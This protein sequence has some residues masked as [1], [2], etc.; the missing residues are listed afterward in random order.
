MHMKMRMTL[1]IEPSISHKAKAVAR[2]KGTSLSGLVETLLSIETGAL[3][4][5]KG[6]PFVEKWG[7]KL[8]LASGSGSRFDYLKA[9]HGL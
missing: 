4:A 9:R 1:T 8:K 2:A 5:K 6:I 7:G 3:S